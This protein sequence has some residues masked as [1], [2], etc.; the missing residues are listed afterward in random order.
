[1][2]LTKIKQRQVDHNGIDIRLAIKQFYNF[3]KYN[4]VKIPLYSYRNDFIVLNENMN[5]INIPKLSKFRK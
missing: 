5:L 4:N 3:S 2:N 1:M